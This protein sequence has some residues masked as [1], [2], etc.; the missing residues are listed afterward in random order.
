[1]KKLLLITLT[2]IFAV[3]LRAQN[4][5]DVW[6]LLQNKN[7]A[8][9]Q[10]KIEECMPTN[11][12]NAKAWLYR[13]NVYLQLYE[14]D[15]DRVAK[16]PAYVT[17]F[18][19]AIF[20]AYESFYKAVELNPKI[21]AI[22]GLVD[23]QTGQVTC[24]STMY[25][26][27]GKAY[28]SGDYATAKKYFTAAAKALAI[29][30]AMKEFV[31]YSYYFLAVIAYQNDK[32]MDAYK[33][34]LNEAISVNTSYAQLYKMA[35]NV[36]SD[37]KDS[38]RCGEILKTAK[39][40]VPEKSRGPIYA[41]ELNH[42][43]TTGDS[44]QLAKCFKNVMKYVG[45][46]TVIP[47]CALSLSNAKKFD[48]AREL[49]DSALLVNPKCFDLLAGFAYAYYLEANEFV[50]LI[51]GAMTRQ[52]LDV[53]DRIALKN[54]LSEERKVIMENAFDWAM[55]AYPFNMKDNSN[56]TIIKQLGVQLQKEV[57][58]ALK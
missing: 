48:M 7:V 44:V 49:L 15:L 6:L 17:K 52:D 5:E 41:I 46:T 16:N 54:K 18:P 38:V 36:A 57:P 20:T 55:R 11:Q 1:M 33:S 42:L 22:S 47:D 27:A 21:E 25:S 56:N 34:I 50:P 13:G 9:A 40:N 19:D 24:G 10:K 37:A 3:G 8:G 4:V 39:K 35:Y 58:D 32:D 45:D 30:P 43:A 31:G 51:N 53:A 12:T 23:P 26:I 2:L 14:R 28:Q 29:D